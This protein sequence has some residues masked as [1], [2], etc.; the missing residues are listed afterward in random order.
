MSIGPNLHWIKFKKVR[1][2]FQFIVL[3]IISL[4]ISFIL[5][6]SFGSK[7]LINSILIFAS[8]YLFF[9]TISDF[10]CERFF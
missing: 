9:V 5:S 10:F 4:L 8:F 6:K 7:N 1:I 3:F 2:K